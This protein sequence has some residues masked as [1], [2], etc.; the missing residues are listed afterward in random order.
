MKIKPLIITTLLIILGGNSQA[1]NNTSSP[2]SIRAYGEQEAFNNAYTRSLGG[3]CNGIR[4]GRGTSY[5]NPASLGAIKFVN[6]D[7]GFRGDYYKIYSATATKTGNNGNFNYFSLGFPAYRTAKYKKVTDTLKNTNQKRFFTEYKN[8][9]NCAFGFTPYS[10][11]NAS[12][13]KTVDSS[14]GQVYNAYSRQGGLNRLFFMNAVNVTQSTSIGLTSSYLFGRSK[15]FDGY[16]ILDTGNARVAVLENNTGFSGFK[17]DLGFQTEKTW[18]YNR[19]IIETKHQKKDTSYKKTP[20]RLV[21]GGTFSPGATLRYN[22]FHQVQN[23]SRSGSYYGIDTVIYEEKVKG[24]S[25]LPSSFSAGFSLTFNDKWMLCAD[26]K[27]EMWGSV[28]KSLYTDSFSNRSQ[29]NIGLAFRP[30]IDVPPG[31]RKMAMPL[32]Y[33]MGFRMLNTG[34]NFKDNSGSIVPLKEYGISFG[35]G[36]PKITYQ[37]TENSVRIPIKNLINITGE[38]VHRGQTGNG[39][40]AE[41]LYRLTVGFTFGNLWFNK[42]KVY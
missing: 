26:Y 4:S 39:M 1:Q 9:W 20:I 24:K 7:F 13:F 40:I 34:Y 31:I 12:Y 25:Y 27:N 37:Y 3:A 36:I 19:R 33:R 2:Y 17:F 41:N 21:F 6:M 23:V 11:I 42:S 28:K 16:Y 18:D 38:Y 35:I 30:D 14:Y 29:I 22:L 15:A 32:E 8:I 10:S 5:E